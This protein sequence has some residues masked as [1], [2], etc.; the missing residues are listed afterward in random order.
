[1]QRCRYLMGRVAAIPGL[2]VPFAATPH[3]TEFV[4]AL[5]GTG[6]TA[7]QVN[8]ALLERGIFGGKDLSADFPA[9]GQ[10]LLLC[11]SELHPKEDLDRLV[12]ALEEVVR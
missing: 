12:E 3:F 1:M 9:L 5:D 7:A 2:R 8:R 6:R 11:V 10:S 4:V